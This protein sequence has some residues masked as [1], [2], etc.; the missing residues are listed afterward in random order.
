MSDCGGGVDGYYRNGKLVL[1]DAK[2]QG[3]EFGF[4]VKTFYIDQNKFLKIIYR[5]Y[6][7]DLEKYNRDYPADKYEFDP[8]KM[9]YTD[10]VYSIILTDPII[11]IKKAGEKITDRTPNQTLTDELVAC[12]Q[13]MN[14]ELQRVIRQVDS[15]KFVKEMPYICETGICGDKLY[16]EVVRLGVSGIA[17]LL[18]EKLDDATP[19]SANVPLFG[20][21]YTVADIAFEAIK[22]I[23]HDIPTF[24]LLGVPFDKDGCGY[25][26]YWQH[27]N[28]NPKNRQKFKTA[29]KTWYH[30]N[31]N[32]L[33]WVKSNDFVTCDCKGQHPDGGHYQLKT[34]E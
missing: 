2:S 25:C 22:E 29:V 32:S 4:L 28:K 3:G 27:V 18:I 6:Y 17:E 31:K 34:N 8:A 23:I 14:I 9:T 12:G 13:E 30:K 10:T 7:A 11:V 16:W 20:G 24:E 19:T 33:I 26:A 21:N 15:L 1:I 5:E